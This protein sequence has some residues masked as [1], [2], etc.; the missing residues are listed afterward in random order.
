MRVSSLLDKRKKLQMA[1][2]SHCSGVP[3]I[4]GFPSSICISMCVEA[5][6]QFIAVVPKTNPLRQVLDQGIQRCVYPAYHSVDD[7]YEN[8]PYSQIGTMSIYSRIS[9]CIAMRA[10]E[11]LSAYQEQ[12]LRDAPGCFRKVGLL[13]M[14][15]H[16]LNIIVSI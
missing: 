16:Y 13:L 6:K 5:L 11:D 7:R 1:L 8:V 10:Q 2:D 12:V 9:S 14:F 3:E 4:G 15:A